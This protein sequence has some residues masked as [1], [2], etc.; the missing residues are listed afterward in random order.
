[1]KKRLVA[2]AIV[3]LVFPGCAG[4]VASVDA[5]AALLEAA[6]ID[7]ANWQVAAADKKAVHDQAASK[8]EG[9]FKAKLAVVTTGAAALKLYEDYKAKDGE[10][11]AARTHDM[12]EYAKSLDNALWIEQVVRR[13][14]GIR[15]GWDALIGRIPAVSTLKDLAEIEAR[16]YMQALASS[17]AKGANP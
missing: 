5:D 4:I 11:A 10:F 2:L 7:V 16:K 1:M 6:K 3:L 12:E 17:P 9:S 8:L 14:I 15:A 13:R